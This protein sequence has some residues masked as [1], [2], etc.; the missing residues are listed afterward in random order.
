V[1]QIITNVNHV[2]V[3]TARIYITPASMFPWWWEN[4]IHTLLV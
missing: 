3:A 4:T 2:T 1:T